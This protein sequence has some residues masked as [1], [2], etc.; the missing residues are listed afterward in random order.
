MRRFTFGW[1]VVLAILASAFIAVNLTVHAEDDSPWITSALSIK[2]Q[3]DTGALPSS[4]NNNVDCSMENQFACSVP[5][6]YGAADQNGAIRLNGTADFRQVA[7]YIDGQRHF[8]PIPNSNTGISYTGGPVYGLYYYFTND[9]SSSLSATRDNGTNIYRINRSPDARLADKSGKL[10]PADLQSMSFSQNG[11]WMV[12]SDPNVAML[13]VNLDTFEVVPF[14]SGFNYTIGYAPSPRTAISNDGHYAVV[15][16]RNFYDFAIYDLGTCGAVPSVITGSLDCKFRDLNK[17]MQDSVAGYTSVDSVRFLADDKLA[18]YAN[19]VQDSKTKT[20]RFIVSTSDTTSR[21]QY[22]ALGDSYISGEGARDYQGGTDTDDNR[23]HVSLV[24]Y[25]YLIGGSLDYSSYHSVACSGAVMNDLS[26]S[27]RDYIGQEDGI[28]KRN[29]TASEINTIL[30][31][32]EPGYLDQLNF[33]QEYQPQA[34]TLSVGGN[35]MGFAGI[36]QKCV[37]P[38]Q[39]NTCYSTYEERLQL[40]NLI[41]QQV[42]PELVSTYQQIKHAGPPDMRLYVIGY[43]QI[44]YPDGDC[45]VNVHLDHDE[46]IFSQQLIGYLDGVLAQAAAKAGVFYVDTQGAL[47]GHR[48]CE[49]GPGSIAMNGLTAGND[50]PR[51]LGGPIG[52][53]SYHPNAFGYHLLENTILGITHGLTDPMPSVNLAAAP[54]PSA[55]L[56]LLDVPAGGQQTGSAELDSSISDDIA[57][58]N[59]SLAVSITGSDHALPPA[60]SLTAVLHS[61]PIGLGTYTTD[62]SGNLAATLQIPVSVPTGYHTLHFYGT[63]LS[64]QAVDIYKTIYIADSPADLDGDGVG[65]SIEPCVGVPASSQDYDQD[66]IDDACDG[67]IDN[68]PTPA[69]YQDSDI[70]SLNKENT[71]NSQ[72]PVLVASEVSPASP[73]NNGPSR[74][75]AA[76]TSNGQAETQYKSSNTLTIAIGLASLA[77]ISLTTW[78][79]AVKNTKK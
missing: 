23:C 50:R 21:V 43:P 35:D 16:S 17:F 66:G 25:P 52:A 75:L 33:V 36:L 1:V 48:L 22:L 40:V 49:A 28:P 19:F 63:D 58:Q 11:Q 53:E 61:T 47:S 12:V 67:T 29:R 79:L 24:S 7:S 31:S 27:S 68:P 20:A 74:V 73:N 2:K 3:A 78:R 62:S 15:A 5:T 56:E 9:I 77:T 44:A 13:R 39:G 64:G 51:V 4:W 71:A 34:V 60:A 18:V 70:S 14:A 8:Q 10:L 42:F 76:N 30:S 38:W 55:G 65:D 46:L 45:A 72:D 26:N 54:P 57:Y 37:E 59:S 41:N 69:A 6:V 32:F